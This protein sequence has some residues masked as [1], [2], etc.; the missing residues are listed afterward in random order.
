MVRERAAL[1]IDDVRYDGAAAAS[2]PPEVAAALSAARVVVV[3]PSN[4]VI[5]IG[6]ILAVPS[7]AE[8]LRA[9]AAPVVAVSPIVGGE[10]LKGPTKPFLE[11]AGVPLDASGIAEYYGDLLDGLVS[12]EEVTLPL[13]SLQTATLLSEPEQRARLAREILDFADGLRR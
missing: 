9:S 7:M 6:P 1:P 5:S 2:V 11:W 12:D 13:P 3:G 8:A 10:I 4:P